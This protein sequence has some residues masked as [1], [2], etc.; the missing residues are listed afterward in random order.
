M[1]NNNN[2]IENTKSNPGWKVAV[3]CLAVALV[4]SGGIFAFFMIKSNDEKAKLQDTI[5]SQQNVKNEECPENATDTPAELPTEDLPE[6]PT[7]KNFLT[8]KEWGVKLEIPD[9]LNYGVTHYVSYYGDGPEE[10]VDIT[11]KISLDG[12]DFSAH[13]YIIRSRNNSFQPYKY[14][15]IG[16]IGDYYYYVEEADLVKA[17]LVNATMTLVSAQ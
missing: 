11:S 12:D 17:L 16:K 5:A 10:F 1:E 3:I 6:E 9:G 2:I 14:R 4:V 7:V 15:K 8:I 13:A